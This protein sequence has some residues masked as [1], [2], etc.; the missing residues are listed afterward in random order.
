[1]ARYVDE[2]EA[3]H[4]PAA[5]PLR[6]ELNMKAALAVA[7]K[8]A[9]KSA[10]AAVSRLDEEYLRGRNATE[11]GNTGSNPVRASSGGRQNSAAGRSA[12]TESAS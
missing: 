5:S 6:G 11:S 4:P 12:L 1:M 9:E 8:D 3:V 7:A 2:A 10:G